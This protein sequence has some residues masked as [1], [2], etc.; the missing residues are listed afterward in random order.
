ME[1]TEKSFLEHLKTQQPSVW[2]LL[3]QAASEDLIV[4]DTEGDAITP[5]NR[6]LLTYP[7]LHNVLKRIINSW[8][9]DS[10]N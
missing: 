7:G 2:A 4:I 10:C 9:E 3:Q 5:S 6:F 1:T 8:A